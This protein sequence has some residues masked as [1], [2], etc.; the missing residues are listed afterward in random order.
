[1]DQVGNCRR[2]S[3]AERGSHQVCDRELGQPSSFFVNN[4]DH[5]SYEVRLRGRKVVE[6]NMGDPRKRAA[7]ASRQQKAHSELRKLF[8][9]VGIDA[10]QLHTDEPYTTALGRFF[11]A[12]EK[13][14]RHG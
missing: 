7:F 9:S 12:R 11:E 13:R 6:I 1:M 14:R 4:V 10:I 8:R 5:I 2:R 3:R